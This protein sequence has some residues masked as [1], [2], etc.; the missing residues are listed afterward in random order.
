MTS[1]RAQGRPLRP[2]PQPRRGLA[3]RDVRAATRRSTSCASRPRLAAKWDRYVAR[4]RTSAVDTRRTTVA[5]KCFRVGKAKA[6]K[7]VELAEREAT[8]LASL[9][10]PQLPAY[11]E[12]FEEDGALYLVMEKIEGESLAALRK[13][14]G[15]ALPRT[16]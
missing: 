14:G 13:R 10:H 16:T 3:G 9:D 11:I 5:I 2:P 12:H 15:A 1:E 8:T 4:D 6:W 7:D